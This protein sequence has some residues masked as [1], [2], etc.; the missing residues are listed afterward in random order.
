MCP[1]VIVVGEASVPPAFR[2]TTVAATFV[3]PYWV[4]I[5]PRGSTVSVEIVSTRSALSTMFEAVTS[6]PPSAADGPYDF[7]VAVLPEY[8][9]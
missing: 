3:E 1:S 4:E 6:M 9:A 7:K 5:T 2:M 8:Q